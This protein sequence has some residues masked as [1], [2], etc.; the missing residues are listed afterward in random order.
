MSEAR[1]LRGMIVLNKG[2]KLIALQRLSKM[3]AAPR[4]LAGPLENQK[5]RST[6]NQS[7]QSTGVML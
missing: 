4:M 3:I 1:E 2:C 7:R 5:I 6:P